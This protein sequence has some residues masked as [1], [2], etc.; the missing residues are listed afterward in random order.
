MSNGSETVIE[1]SMNQG[2]FISK[3]KVKEKED[4]SYGLG[5]I[6]QSPSCKEMNGI[7]QQFQKHKSPLPFFA[8]QNVFGSSKYSIR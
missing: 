6:S 8:A 3:Y 5:G 7:Q 2:P 1:N 4:E